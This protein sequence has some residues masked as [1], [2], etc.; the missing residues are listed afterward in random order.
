MRGEYTR[1]VYHRV[2]ADCI[3]NAWKIQPTGPRFHDLRLYE[4]EHEDCG[5]Y[6]NRQKVQFE[7]VEG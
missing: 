7:E 4:D 5:I 3:E 6:R 2:S 1:E